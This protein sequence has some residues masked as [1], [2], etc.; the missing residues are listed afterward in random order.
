[1]D[2]GNSI[3]FPKYIFYG[4]VSDFVNSAIKIQKCPIPYSNLAMLYQQHSYEFVANRQ[5]GTISKTS[6]LDLAADDEF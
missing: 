3:L 5:K 2:L 4:Q 6:S 1:M